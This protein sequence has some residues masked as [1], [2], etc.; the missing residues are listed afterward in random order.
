MESY[1][2]QRNGKGNPLYKE[3]SNI[4]DKNFTLR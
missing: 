1:F 3:L 4:N 2:I